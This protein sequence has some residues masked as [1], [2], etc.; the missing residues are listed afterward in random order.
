[1]AANTFANWGITTTQSILNV[2]EVG[3]ENEVWPIVEA[4]EKEEFHAFPD[5][6]A[7]QVGE[8]YQSFARN[9]VESEMA[10]A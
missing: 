3:F 1:M 5:T 2:Q 10:E 7:K 8:A 6:M 4:L 9:V